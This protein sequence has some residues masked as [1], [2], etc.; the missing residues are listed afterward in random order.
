M[1]NQILKIVTFALCIA[2]A[3]VI[4]AER[5]FGNVS[6]ELPEVESVYIGKAMIQMAGSSLNRMNTGIDNIMIK[7]AALENINAIEVINCDKKS[8]IKRLRLYTRHTIYKHNL[9]VLMEQKSQNKSTII[10]GKMVTEN[11]EQQIQNLIIENC[12]A[13]SY[14]LIH[15][16]GITSPET[17]NIRL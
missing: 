1:K 7:K 13:D 11:G 3:Q 16:D 17:M 4:H 2:S 9:E 6:R 8:L 14:Q 12:N 5:L 10:Y 15:I